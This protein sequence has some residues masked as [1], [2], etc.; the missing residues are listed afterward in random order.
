[1]GRKR[2]LEKNNE[3]PAN[4]STCKPIHELKREYI[5][6]VDECTSDEAV[7]R[8]F[9]KLEETMF[10]EVI[11]DRLMSDLSKLKVSIA[12]SKVSCRIF[13]DVYPQMY[14]QKKELLAKHLS[15]RNQLES[16]QKYGRIVCIV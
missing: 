11:V 2:I 12:N 3:H 7:Y 4:A 6:S 8:A 1:M 16:E 9:T 13:D 15:S 10:T 5:L 14:V